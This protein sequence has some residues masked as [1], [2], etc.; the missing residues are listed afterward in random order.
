MSKKNNTS[1]KVSGLMKN[2]TAKTGNIHTPK[3]SLSEESNTS[4]NMSDIG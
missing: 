4:I 1:M 2:T 3:D